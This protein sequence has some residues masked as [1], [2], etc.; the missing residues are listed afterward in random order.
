MNNTDSTSTVVSITDRLYNIGRELHA[1]DK[2]IG[3]CID[4]SDARDFIPDESMTEW[5]PISTNRDQRWDA[6]DMAVTKLR[7]AM[8][9][10]DR[11]HDLSIAVDAE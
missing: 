2:E 8:S 7:D 5:H 3:A 10:L 9:L 4:A 1:L 6:M 11:A